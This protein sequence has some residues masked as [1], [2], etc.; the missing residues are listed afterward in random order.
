[1][2]PTPRSL[3]L[4]GGLTAEQRP[5][6]GDGEADEQ[7]RCSDEVAPGDQEEFRFSGCAEAV[8]AP[9]P[10]ALATNEFELRSFLLIS[11]FARSL[12]ALTA[13]LGSSLAGD[14]R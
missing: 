4:P 9:Q 10:P 8:P 12:Q 5:Q 7:L 14:E 2:R 6:L 13:A 11:S 3:L 1:M